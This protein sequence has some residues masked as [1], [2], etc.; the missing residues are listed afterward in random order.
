MID[1]VAPPD[2]EAQI[3][4]MIFAIVL[5]DREGHIAKANNAA[6]QMLGRS[7]RALIGK[8][9]LDDLVIEDERVRGNLEKGET[10]LIARDLPIITGGRV[11][12]VNFTSSPLDSHPGWRVITLSDVGKVGARDNEIEAREVRAPAILA[13][14]IKNPLSA[15]RGASQLLTRRLDGRDRPLAQLI[16]N[17][18]DRIAALIDRMQQLGAKSAVDIEPC[19]P[20][21]SIRNAMAVVRASRLQSCELVEEFDPS[22]PDVAADRGALEQVLIN[23]IG[24]ACEACRDV[25]GARITV[26]TRY[27]SGLVSNAVRLGKAIKLPIEITVTDPG[28]GID[29]HLRDHVFEP[30]VSSKPEGQGLGLALVRKLLRDMGGRISHE[31]DE[32]AGNTHFRINMPTIE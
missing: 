3:A 12:R 11:K 14:E 13:H 9:L 18:V 20:H 2:A 16:S 32:R 31:R 28:P 17:E 4:G 29:P 26:Q 8:S 15:I 1:E 19:N 10:Q 5:L 23:L 7:A 21:E 24:N 27:V 22:L 25:H 6:E 30:F